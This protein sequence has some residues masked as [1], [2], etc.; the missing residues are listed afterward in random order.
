[1]KQAPRAQADS[2]G[3]IAGNRLQLLENGEE[4]F[5]A[6]F[7]AIA[8]AQSEVIVE[9]FILFDDLVGRQLQFALIEA[10]K[11]GVSVDITVDGYGSPDLSPQFIEELTSVGVRFHIYDQQPRFLGLR[12]NI[13]RRMHRK[14]VAVD[15]A[16]AFVGGINFGADQLASAGEKSKQDY[17][18]CIDG[19]LAHEIHE[20]ARRQVEAFRRTRSWWSRDLSMRWPSR[21]SGRWW[22][23][24]DNKASRSGKA[25]FVY[26]DNDRHRDDIERHYRSAMR[27]AKHEIVIACAYFFPGYLFLKHLRNAARRGVRV[28][29]MLQGNPDMPQAQAWASLLYPSLLNAGVE[30]LE[31]CQRPLHAKVAVIDE[32]WCTVGSSNLDPLSL[33][34]NLEANVVVHDAEFNRELRSRLEPLL[35][36]HCRRID[37]TQMSSRGSIWSMFS[38]FVSYHCTR[39]FP[40]WAGWLPANLPNLQSVEPT[41]PLESLSHSYEASGDHG[42]K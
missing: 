36:Q 26:R 12:T 40:R 23:R 2:G 31:Y 30:I 39:Y 41:P 18:M 20:F 3:W 34:L 28:K 7:D 11:R 1:M 16:V 37:R 5:P 4:Y 42:P 33:A 32:E 9:T 6:V 8:A 25:I 15:D 14:I 22:R 38:N 13:F 35:T 19:P 27:T 17:S 29:L 24:S 21:W 10:A